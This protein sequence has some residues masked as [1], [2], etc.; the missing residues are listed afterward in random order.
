[1][2]SLLIPVAFFAILELGLRAVGFGGSDALFVDH[3]DLAGY[4]QP[5]PDVMRRYVET[6][7]DPAARIPPFLFRAE[8][9]AAGVRLVVQGASTAAGF[10]YGRWGGLAGMLTDRF[11]AARPD[12]GIEVVSTALAAVSSYTL[13]DLADEI[14]AIEPDAVLVYAGHNEYVGILGAGSALTAADSRLAAGLHLHLGASRVY[15]LVERAVACARDVAHAV[16]GADRPTLFARAAEAARAP[17]GSDRHLA[18]LTSFEANMGALLAKYRA[19]GVPVYVGT[20]VSNERDLPPFA[21]GPAPEV[22]AARFVGH[23]A[24][25]ERAL[26]AGDL[27]AARGAV[28]A[29]RA[30]DADAADAWFALGRLELAADAPARAHDA[31][32]RARDLDALRF[33]APGAINEIVRSLARRHGAT[34]VEVERR[35]VETSPP[36]GPGDTLLLEH[37]HPNADGY[38]LLA[39]T[40][41]EALR[42]DGLLGPLDDAPPFEAAHRDMPL[43]ELDRRVAALRVQE[44]RA[45]FPFSDPPRAV[46]LP[47]TR[48]AV[49]QLA[50]LLHAGAIR[51]ID[52]MDRLLQIRTKE[53]RLLDAARVARLAAHEYPGDRGPNLA[54]GLLALQ[55]GQPARAQLYLARSHRAAPDDVRTLAS[56]LQAD[57][58]VGD[59]VAAATHVELLRRL[60]PGHPLIAGGRADSVSLREAAGLR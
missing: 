7:G 51:W 56:L 42:R 52:A 28:D 40:Y 29:L 19:A 36:G 37:V 57:R 24:D 12:A 2:A 18:G 16:R 9:P 53:G 3:P 49:E 11:E 14:I 48:D 26:A 8:K 59:A 6:C 30:L 4:R 1:M 13:L 33:R 25:F 5:N 31:F 10:P 44:L 22:D 39:D 23:R 45:G 55:A 38:F 54:A 17:F 32:R 43:T 60:R 21:G 41:F 50:R 15:R 27:A 34:V 47:P 20:V 46:M 58:A 35:F